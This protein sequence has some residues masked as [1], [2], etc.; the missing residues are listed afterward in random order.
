M[1]NKLFN[2]EIIRQALGLFASPKES[3]SPSD[4]TLNP[5]MP[6]GSPLL[7]FLKRGQKS[8]RVDEGRK[9]NFMGSGDESNND[10]LNQTIEED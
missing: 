10:I 4:G 3:K 1:R 7:G 9:V 8:P 2:P 5:N 6:G